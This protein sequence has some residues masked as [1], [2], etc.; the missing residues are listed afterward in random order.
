MSV[1]HAAAG[2][3][4]V[5]LAPSASAETLSVCQ[6]GDR[7]ERHLT[8]IVDGDTGWE[9]GVK[10]RY[11]AIDTPEMSGHAECKAESRRAVEARDRLRQLMDSGYTINW[12]GESGSYGR[13]LVTITLADGRDAGNVLMAEGLAQPWPNDGNVWCGR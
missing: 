3:I 10:W 4:V 1:S 8:C 2:A 5:M 7:A 13:K 6:G 12:S 11:E 9:N